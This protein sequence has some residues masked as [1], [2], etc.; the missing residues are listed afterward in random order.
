MFTAILISTIAYATLLILFAITLAKLPKNFSPVNNFKSFSIIIPF[1]NE[2]QRIGPLLS[3]LQNINY[4]S[5]LYE[6]IWV[7][8]H[9]SDRTVQVIEKEKII[10][11][12]IINAT[13][14]G[15]KQAIAEGAA[16]ASKEYL[17]FI[18]ADTSFDRNFLKGW[19]RFIQNHPGTKFMFGNVIMQGGTDFLSFFQQIEFAVLQATGIAS[20][21]LKS[22]I[23][24][25]A[26]NMCIKKEFLSTLIDDIRFD[27][28]SGDDMFLLFA[29]KKHN[30]Q[31]I[32]WN[33]LP[34]STV[35]TLPE[36]SLTSFVRQRIRWTGKGKFF[37]DI[38]TVAT[39][40][41]VYAANLSIMVSWLAYGLFPTLFL[42]LIKI[43]PEIFLLYVYNHTIANRGEIRIVKLLFFALIYPLYATVLIPTGLILFR[44]E[45]P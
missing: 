16:H 13:R 10:C 34:E 9:S 42:L 5:H 35:F 7:N 3:S 2:S 18:D 41:C 38:T 44:K 33:Y 17:I 15:K 45:K 20:T 6:I 29:A 26:S 39:G 30:R 4:P 32:A 23:T 21:L 31:G 11:S 19:N 40:F 8:D 28:P 27:I 24:G 1:K 43:L 12:R 37:N 25:S 36:T 22:G 14:T